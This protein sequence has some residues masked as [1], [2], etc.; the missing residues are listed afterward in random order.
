VMEYRT[1]RHPDRLFQTPDCR[2]VIA[3]FGKATASTVEDLAAASRQM[4]LADLRH[5]KPD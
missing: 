4:V 2:S 1:A 5:V 3:V